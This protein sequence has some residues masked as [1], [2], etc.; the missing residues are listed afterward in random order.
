MGDQGRMVQEMIDNLSIDGDQEVPVGG[1]ADISDDQGLCDLTLEDVPASEPSCNTMG[2]PD[3]HLEDTHLISAESQNKSNVENQHQAT[4]V[5]SESSYTDENQHQVKEVVSE[6]SYIDENQHYVTK[7]V[8]VSTDRDENQHYLTKEVSVSTDRDENHHQVTKVVSESAYI[9]ENQC[10]VTD[11]FS[12]SVHTDEDREVQ[13][14]P[15]TKGATNSSLINT[16]AAINSLTH[17]LRQQAD[18]SITAAAAAATGKVA[19]PEAQAT[20]LVLQVIKSALVRVSSSSSDG[21]QNDSQLEHY[22]EVVPVESFIEEGF[23]WEGPISPI[24]GLDEESYSDINDQSDMSGMATMETPEPLNLSQEI[25]R[26]EA[27]AETA[28]RVVNDV[29]LCVDAN[30]SPS[31]GFEKSQQEAG[32]DVKLGVEG[33]TKENDKVAT[34]RLEVDGFA[35]EGD[36]LATDAILGADE[37]Q[38]MA[39]VRFNL[40]ATE[41]FLNSTIESSPEIYLDDS[42][43]TCSYTSESSEGCTSKEEIL[44]YSSDAPEEAHTTSDF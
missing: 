37:E 3:I 31:T 21:L 17:S 14:E 30:N 32:G 10:T 8:S 2:S 39:R 18:V 28:A 25:K 33:S 26:A 15:E 9:D 35:M 27:M 20:T 5:V 34:N 16:A 44:I 38:K 19:Y 29:L 40:P 42:E 12:E 41:K 43:Y 1:D 23:K 24:F 11:V 13:L 6:S 22:T 4:E 36:R 7:E